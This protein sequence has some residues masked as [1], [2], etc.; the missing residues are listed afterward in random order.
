ME[1][2]HAY[3]FNQ[4]AA[5]T[6]AQD[7]S[8]DDTKK[9]ELGKVAVGTGEV[10]GEGNLKK[11]VGDDKIKNIEFVRM[12]D[13]NGHMVMKLKATA[14]WEW[15]KCIYPTLPQEEKDCGYCTKKHFGVILDGGMTVKM[16]DTKLKGGGEAPE[17]GE[18]QDF[19]GKAGNAYFIDSHHDAVAGDGGMV[20]C[21]FSG[22]WP[23]VA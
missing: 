16:M 21:E 3:E 17:A 5:A 14:G 15:S 13:L 19:E 6:Y 8:A 7:G 11:L 1:E 2:C 18:S 4:A 9:A 23:T 20:G 12:Y 10:E 22:F